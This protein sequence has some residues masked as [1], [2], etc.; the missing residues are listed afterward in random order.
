MISDYRDNYKTEDVII[1]GCGGQECF[2]LVHLSFSFS[3]GSF[4]QRT[5]QKVDTR[6]KIMRETTAVAEFLNA[7]FIS[8][9]QKSENLQ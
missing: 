4:Y 9:L 6:H 5:Y 1:L 7:D 3:L 2:K 8:N